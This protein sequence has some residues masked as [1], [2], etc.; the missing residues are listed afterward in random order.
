MEQVTT[1]QPD[2][3]VCDTAMPRMDGLEFVCHLRDH[4]DGTPVIL[5]SDVEVEHDDSLLSILGA[6]KHISKTKSL[7]SLVKSIQSVHEVSQRKS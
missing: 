4:N 1:F 7:R 3:I 5:T 2:V 6:N